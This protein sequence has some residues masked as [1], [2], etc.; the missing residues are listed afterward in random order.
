M[1]TIAIAPVKTCIR[2]HGTLVRSQ[3]AGL[4]VTIGAHTG[5]KVAG[6][7]IHRDVIVFRSVHQV[8]GEVFAQGQVIV[9]LILGSYRDVQ[10]RIL[11]EV[12][13]L[14][15]TI[16]IDGN[17]IGQLVVVV[18]VLRQ[19]LI[20]V[21]FVVHINKAIGEHTVGVGVGT[22]HRALHIGQEA[23]CGRG[24]FT[25]VKCSAVVAQV[26]RQLGKRNVEA[27]IKLVGKLNIGIETDIDTVHVVA[28]QCALLV[29][30]AQ[31]KVIV[32]HI[33]TTTYIDVVVLTDA[34]AVH[35]LLPVGIVVILGIVV[36][37]RILVEEL[38]VLDG[39]VGR[40]QEV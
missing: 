18:V 9:E 38:E 17:R 34:S 19:S 31:G 24:T 32:G 16:V 27:S 33:I 25:I 7:T 15:I 2:E 1:C 4:I 21:A 40:R 26:A 23:W 28:H 37:G 10:H 8:I 12:L 14:G 35:I 11:I 22:E 39:S 29:Y 20:K 5:H 36:I 30:I 13:V 6:H 3:C